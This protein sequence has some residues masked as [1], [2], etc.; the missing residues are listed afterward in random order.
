MFSMSGYSSDGHGTLNITSSSESESESESDK[1][2]GEDD[3]LSSLL[4][5]DEEQATSHDPEL[6]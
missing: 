1:V 2:R 5:G 6:G 4:W 3:D